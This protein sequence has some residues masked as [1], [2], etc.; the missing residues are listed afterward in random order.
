MRGE[1]K[2]AGQ[3]LV[4]AVIGGGGGTRSVQGAPLV[5]YNEEKAKIYH[6]DLLIL[7][8]AIKFK[9]ISLNTK[10]NHC[11]QRSFLSCI[12]MHRNIHKTGICSKSH[13]KRKIDQKRYLLYFV[14]NNK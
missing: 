7:S 2:V 6:H 12:Q 14:W 5:I 1:D 9:V 13:K 4:G 8:A 11:F 3:V 10:P